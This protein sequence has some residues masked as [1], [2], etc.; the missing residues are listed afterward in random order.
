MSW[1][2]AALVLGAAGLLLGLLAGYHR[3]GWTAVPVPAQLL[4]EHG[5]LMTG[6]FFGTLIALERAVALRAWWAYVP[7]WLCG[8]SVVAF[9]LGA[10]LTG[11]GLL[12]L[13]GVGIA[14]V[15]ATLLRR[16]RMVPFVLLLGA[17]GSFA[18]AWIVALLQGSVTPAVPLLMGFFV[19]TIVAE[20]LELT[21]L[22]GL[23]RRAVRWLGVALIAVL[24]GA[25]W[26]MVQQRWELLGLALGGI[27]LWLF[28]YDVAVRN[29]RRAATPLHRY[30]GAML[31]IGYGWL[32]VSMM[33]MLLGT[34]AVAFAFDA[35]LHSFFVGFV[36][37]MVFAHGVIIFPAVL[38]RS[39][40]G[41]TPW[42]WG[43]AGLLFAGM[44]MRLLGDIGGT[45]LR[46]WGSWTIGAALVLYLAMVAGA[47]L[48]LA[49][50]G[51]PGRGNP[52][53]V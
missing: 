4:P 12:A 32:L 20:R 38:Q 16:H 3:M 50:R 10:A 25:L 43:P 39:G 35:M 6:T 45:P 5:A 13:G 31:G 15:F 22:L 2:R 29:L 26:A 8:A 11:Y 51:R 28:R 47:T 48:R 46:L 23:E 9:L 53:A 21:R 41:W 7:A 34:R 44:G 30:V 36:L 18:A 40:Y 19:V 42:L 17:G 33:V 52:T 49:R 37:T 24:L 1:L 27:A 14:A